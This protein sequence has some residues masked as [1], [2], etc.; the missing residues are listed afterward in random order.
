M[1]KHGT[2][3]ILANRKQGALYTGVT[4]DLPKRM[5]QHRNETM[6]GFTAE[7]DIKKLMWFEVHATIAA[8]ILREKQIKKW[9]R[10][11][12]IDLIETANPD[13]HDLAVSVLG[14]DPLTPSFPRSRE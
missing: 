5:Y 8:A 7:Y 13:W 4:S 9:R 10:A 11:W 12:K 1:D 2:V 6:N 14:C 3:Y